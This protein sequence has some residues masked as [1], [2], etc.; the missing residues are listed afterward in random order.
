MDTRESNLAWWI[1]GILLILLIIVGYLW[2]SQ[3]Q[4]LPTVLENGQSAI[5]A[6]RDQIAKDCNADMHSAACQQDLS[7]LSSILAQFSTDIQNASTTAS[8]T[9][10]GSMS[11]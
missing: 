8:T 1:A 7:D 10:S 2:L 5:A 9:T 6:E 11:Y 4:S 3:K